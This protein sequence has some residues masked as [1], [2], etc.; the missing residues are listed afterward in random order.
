MVPGAL[1]AA[2]VPVLPLLADPKSSQPA[3]L[4]RQMG[5]FPAATRARRPAWI[6]A[7]GDGRGRAIPVTAQDPD[8]APAMACDAVRLR[9]EGPV[10]PGAAART[11]SPD[12]MTELRGGPMQRPGPATPGGRIAMLARFAGRAPRAGH[13]GASL[14]PGGGSPGGTENAGI[15]RPLSRGMSTCR[16]AS[17]WLMPSAGA[18]RTLRDCPG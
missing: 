9:P 15:L 3:V 17:R 5:S 14:T 11:I 8:H 7:P 16:A 10:G 18:G 4:R 13:P 2:L 1:F 6:A 12:M